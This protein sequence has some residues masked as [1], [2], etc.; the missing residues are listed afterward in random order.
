MACRDRGRAGGWS[1]HHAADLAGCS[2][3]QLDYWA[4][5]DLIRPSLH[6]AAGSGSRRRY[7]YPDV[8]RLC[9]VTSLVRGG[10]QLK[11]L[12][13]HL[14]PASANLSSGY[15]LITQRAMVHITEERLPAV[16]D[17]LTNR[18]QGVYQVLPLYPETLRLDA[19][20]RRLGLL[21]IEPEAAAS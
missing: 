19:Q 5:T 15:L 18:Y 2:Y 20:I 8:V 3:R 12:R 6:D 4:R 13:G 7:A 11:S 21:G 16:V 17:D 14:P 9:L 1:A 10:S